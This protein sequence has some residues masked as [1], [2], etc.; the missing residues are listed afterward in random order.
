MSFSALFFLFVGGLVWIALLRSLGAV[1]V[2]LGF[3][4]IATGWRISLRVA[5]FTKKETTRRSIKALVL[6]ISYLLCEVLPS[7]IGGSI[8]VVLCALGTRRFFP[9]LFSV[10]LP[11]ASRDAIFFLSFGISLSPDLQVAIIDEE[12]KILYVHALNA[13]RPEDLQQEIRRQ[14]ERYLKEALP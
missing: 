7:I 10:H 1:D 6:T 11:G 14:F 12:K 8:D 3:L 2:I 9:A 4:V 5:G 13:P